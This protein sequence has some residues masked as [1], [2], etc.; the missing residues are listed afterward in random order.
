MSDN[1]KTPEWQEAGVVSTVASRY[2]ALRPVP[3]QA[4]RMGDGFWKARIDAGRRNGIAAFLAWLDVDDQTAPFRAYAAGDRAGIRAGLETLEANPTGMN[5]T[6][7]GHSWRANFQKWLEACAFFIQSGH[8]AGTRALLDLFVHGVVRAHED[9]AFW[10]V[11]YGDGFERSYGL[12]NPGHLIQAAIAHH[13]AT[14]STEFLECA[15]RVADAIC[16]KF[17]GEDFA[18]HS[19]IEMALVELYRTTGQERYLAGARHFLTPLLRQPPV[20]GSPFRGSASRHVVRQTYL[21]CGGADYYAETG[22]REFLDKLTAIWEDMGGGKLHLTGQLAVDGENIEMTCKEAFELHTG[23]FR[24]LLGTGLETCEAVGNA[25]W[26]WRMLAVTGAARYADLMERTLYNGFLAHV[27]LDGAKFHYLCPLSSD[28]NHWQRTAWAST[29]T[30]CCPPNALRMLASL[31][32]YIFSTSQDGV[33]V[34]L[35]DGCRMDWRL[36][37]G[38]GLRL[39]QETAYPWDGEVA[40]RLEPERPV[41]FALNLRIPAWCRAASLQVNGEAFEGELAPGAY[42]R[43]ERVWRSGDLVVLRLPMP[44]VAVTADARAR[45]YEG[46]VALCRGPLVYS[47]ESTDNPGVGMWGA[48]VGLPAGDGPGGRELTGHYRQAALLDEFAVDYRQDLL[49][50]VVALQGAGGSYDEP[51]GKL[52][53]IPYYAWGNRE[54]RSSL[55]TWIDGR[56]QGE[57]GEDASQTPGV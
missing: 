42:C 32:G 7:N 26:N 2:A 56:T 9:D 39:T 30:G 4:V 20:V 43:I 5:R 41:A 54:S 21:L 6:R 34:H 14:G 48:W 19:V 17:G 37:D 35:Y 50:G 33:W 23:V 3:L 55:R 57:E 1:G 15:Q 40:I 49:G 46:K 22:D 36:Q 11:Y 45:Y 47:V 16:Q 10:A 52:T 25:T 24:F 18:G 31:P 51:A 27:S 53:F 29:S 28:G 12:G 38:T 8:D 13:R 44:V